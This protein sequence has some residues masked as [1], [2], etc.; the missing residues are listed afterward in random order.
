MTGFSAWIESQ[1]RLPQINNSRDALDIIAR[2][3]KSLRIRYP[4]FGTELAGYRKKRQRPAGRIVVTDDPDVADGLITLDW[5][6]YPLLIDGHSSYDFSPLFGLPVLYLMPDRFWALDV[7][8]Q[9]AEADPSEFALIWPLT[10]KE[11]VLWS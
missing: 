1:P 11:E 6:D 4:V 2:Y 9:I 5:A 7:A 3:R 8:C 10:E